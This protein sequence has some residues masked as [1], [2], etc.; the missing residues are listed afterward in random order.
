MTRQ[1][2]ERIKDLIAEAL[3]R[4]PSE[5]EAFLRARC[6]PDMWDEVH[7]WLKWCQSSF[8]EK[9]LPG[10]LPDGADELPPGTK[11]GS[12]V[13]VDALGKGGMG[14]VYLAKSALHHKVALKRLFGSTETNAE[15]R[16]RILN[17]AVLMA[18]INHPNVATI[19][20]T[21]EDD[22]GS[23]IVMEYVE[24]ESLAARLRRGRLPIDSVLAIG[25]QLSAAIA[26]A[27]AKGIVHRDLK[28]A[29]IQL[30]VDGTVKVLDFGVAAVTSAFTTLTA[31]SMM[32][33][34]H[35]AQP[36]TPGY[37]SP[38]Q[39][40]S[41][42]VDER[43][44]IFSLGI[45][46][47]E[48]AT[49]QRAYEFDDLLELATGVMR[50]LR[51]A[52]VVDSTVPRAL[53]DVIAKAVAIDPAARF[54]TGAEVHAALEA[55]QRPSSEPFNLMRFARWSLAGLATVVAT[56]VIGFLTCAQFD[57]T[58]GRGEEFGDH[59]VWNWLLWGGRTLILPIAYFLLALIVV[60]IVVA[61]WRLL[62]S[63]LPPV[64]RVGD[65]TSRSVLAVISRLESNDSAPLPQLLLIVQVAI[66]AFAFWWFGDIIGAFWKPLDY[67]DAAVFAILDPKN[68]PRFLY[69][70]CFLL[71]AAAMAVAW[72]LLLRRSSAQSRVD[73]PTLAAGAAVILVMF[74]MPQLASRTLASSR[75]I[76]TYAGTRC[77]QTGES[78][79]KVLLFCPDIDPP[80]VRAVDKTEF[81]PD[82]NAYFFVRPTPPE[83]KR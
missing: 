28:P 69:R 47:F 37:M 17:E 42:R 8:L 6:N 3:E 62:R 58:F 59:S 55:V 74:V 68:V 1:T 49:G 30:T 22:A 14:Q 19:H 65:R 38:E 36:G 4:R 11:V 67:A 50:P 63:A 16:A 9:P 34:T 80:R 64:R 15:E 48:M 82:D 32:A 76:G 23:F 40:L 31:G 45:V 54:Q 33:A 78:R 61:V 7:T 2:W 41:D 26:A 43:S 18:Q 72:Y 44:D 20:H 21:V 60:R 53:A 70:P 5:R 12:Y 75:P 10:A 25:S 71:L 35:G 39:L 66:A 29:N 13:I 73:R 56:G 24:G 46:L 79:N 52:D 77:Y 51:R 81:Q 83:P 57:L 27:H